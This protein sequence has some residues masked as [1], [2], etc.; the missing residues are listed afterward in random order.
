MSPPVIT[1]VA[2]IGDI[3]K[4]PLNSERFKK[5]T[6]IYVVSNSKIKIALGI[7]CLPVSAEKGMEKT[8][9]KFY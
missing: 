9:P 8:I 2:Q 1:F 6:E 4:L 7:D 3:L 5:L